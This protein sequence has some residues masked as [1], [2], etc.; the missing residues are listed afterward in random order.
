MIVCDMSFREAQRQFQFEYTVRHYSLVDPFNS[1]II[2]FDN[3][4]H[5]VIIV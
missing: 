2:I 5:N 4:L 3:V 1:V